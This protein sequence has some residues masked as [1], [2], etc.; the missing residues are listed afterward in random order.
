MI[1]PQPGQKTITMSG[2]KLKLLQDKYSKEIDSRP[3]LSFASFIADSA[4]IELERRQIIRQAPFIAL[5][6]LH[7]DIITLKD[8]RKKEKFVEVQ[9]KEKKLYCNTCEK[10]CIHVGFAWALPEVRRALNH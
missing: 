10:E 1:L 2:K 7:D 8:F 6:A 9:I 4:L 3:T 5:I